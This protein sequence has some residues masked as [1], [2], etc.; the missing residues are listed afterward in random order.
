MKRLRV[1]LRAEDPLEFRRSFAHRVGPRQL[2]LP[3]RRTLEPGEPVQ[4]WILYRNRSVALSGHGHVRVQDKGADSRQTWFDMEWSAASRSLL[5]AVLATN[6]PSSGPTESLSTSLDL[7]AD[8]DLPVPGVPQPSAPPT[9]PP[10]PPSVAPA[11]EPGEVWPSGRPAAP[12][13]ERESG[14]VTPLARIELVRQTPEPLSV[15]TEPRPLF[16]GWQRPVPDPAPP[17]KLVV[18]V[19]LGSAFTRAAAVVGG[20]PS[21]VPTRR[22][23][24]AL[25]SVV[26]IDASGKTIVGEPAQR[27]AQRSPHSAIQQVRRLMGQTAGSGLADHVGQ[28]MQV[29]WTAGEAFQPAAQIGPHRIPVEEV[30][31]LLFK[32]VREG[33]ALVLPDR[34]N[35]GVFTVPGWAGPRV[36]EAT[37]RAAA[38]AGFHVER[39]LG[40]ALA[41]A[42]SHQQ[43]AAGARGRWLVV[44]LGA[45]QLDVARLR[46]GPGLLEVEAQGGSPHLGGAELD[47]ALLPL[48]RE[49]VER[50]SVEAPAP[51]AAF[52]AGLWQAARQGKE[53][54]SASARAEVQVEQ[55]LPDGQALRVRVEL[56]RAEAEQRWEPFF[57]DL[58]AEVTR[59]AG[60]GDG[61]DRLLVAGGVQSMPGLKARLQQAFPSAQLVHL[62]LDAAA[63]GAALVADRLERGADTGI[64][65]RL[66]VGVGLAGSSAGRHS[67]FVP[68][69]ALPVQAS[70]S[71]VRGACVLF[72]GPPPQALGTCVPP[73]STLRLELTADG[74]LRLFDGSDPVSLDPV[75]APD[76]LKALLQRPATPVPA[77]P[78]GGDRNGWLGWFRKAFRT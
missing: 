68:G 42:V 29:A 32:E 3:V 18:G 46:V 15:A 67:L 19:D 28:Q 31:A 8:L 71:N 78:A 36:R 39:L 27:R 74:V 20:R 17:G 12:E 76:D 25:P 4:I 7:S 58:F 6:P 56:D 48:L 38:L 52:E 9:A 41:A 37:R 61:V 55:P 11:R 45:G 44:A 2:R 13:A 49:S 30:A 57:Q 69:Q 43:D 66:A 22:G 54:L 10:A 64:R 34:A 35:R 63:R 26:H 23:L 77:A 73:G 62:P 60:S 75:V 59:T 47:A 70:V 65:E 16:P 33:A 51:T 14:E 72:E 5:A 1:R 50:A 53:R 40:E 24:E 21:M